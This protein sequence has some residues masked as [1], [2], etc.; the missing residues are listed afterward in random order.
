MPKASKGTASESADAPGFEGHYEK[1]EGGYTVGFE[2]YTE[3][4]DMAPLFKRLPDDRCQSP[5]WGYVIKGRVAYDV[6]GRQEAIEAG[7]A[8][9]VPPG[10]TPK[11]FAAPRSSSSARATSSTG[12]SR[13]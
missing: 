12:R 5:H 2:T 4:A 13:R 11:I 3:D 10:H 1:L 7:E 6:G 9:Y 8:Y